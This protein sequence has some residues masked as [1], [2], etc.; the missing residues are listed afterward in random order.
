[1][2]SPLQ[3]WFEGHPSPFVQPDVSLPFP[4]G[5]VSGPL[6]PGLSQLVLDEGELRSHHLVCMELGKA[7]LP[8]LVLLM[9]G[10]QWILCGWIEGPIV[11]L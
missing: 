6:W 8:T 1:V 5:L 11:P 3:T 9:A 2:L 7:H 4:L 10:A